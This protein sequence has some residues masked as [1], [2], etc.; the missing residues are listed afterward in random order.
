MVLADEAGLAILTDVL[1]AAKRIRV[2]RRALGALHLATNRLR[3]GKGAFPRD[4]EA[5]SPRSQ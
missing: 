1:P 4:W 3:T 5:A 2:T